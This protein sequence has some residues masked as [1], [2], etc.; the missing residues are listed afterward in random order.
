MVYYG[1]PEEVRLHGLNKIGSLREDR[2]GNLY[3]V[4]SNN[5][6]Y[7]DRYKN[8]FQNLNAELGIGEG[9]HTTVNEAT[10][11]DWLLCTGPAIQAE[12]FEWPEF[13]APPFVSYKRWK[14]NLRPYCSNKGKLTGQ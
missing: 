2:K 1:T 11:N 8:T 6:V 5:V 3:I 4:T 7:F 12:H 9:L 13:W 14:M 10:F